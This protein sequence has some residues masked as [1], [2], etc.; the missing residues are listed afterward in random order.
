MG[1]SVRYAFARLES[2]QSG[3]VGQKIMPSGMGK[4]Q[5]A[6]PGEGG[7]EVPKTFTSHYLPGTTPY[8]CLVARTYQ[9]AH[10]RLDAASP[11]FCGAVAGESTTMYEVG[12]LRTYYSMGPH[13]MQVR[14]TH[15][16][17]VLVNT[18]VISE[19]VQL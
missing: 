19:P 8:T 11:L 3:P 12:I 18:R 1:C 4:D 2:G 5:V 7:G 6:A 17:V 10:P 15:L 16:V 9:E 13:I 14:S